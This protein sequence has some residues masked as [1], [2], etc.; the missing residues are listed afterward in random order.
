MINLKKIVPSLLILAA[1]STAVA[2]TN[3]A[4][5]RILGGEV[6]GTD[7]APVVV[8]HNGKSYAVNKKRYRA[9]AKGNHE[10]FLQAGMHSFTL[11][12]WDRRQYLKLN[13]IL[14]RN[15]SPLSN[16]PD[17]SPFNHESV[18]LSLDAN[19]SYEIALSEDSN[20]VVKFK[21]VDSA[22]AHCEASEEEILPSYTKLDFGMLEPEIQAKLIALGKSA[23][24]ALSSAN[25]KSS[26]TAVHMAGFFGLSVEPKEGTLVVTH[27]IRGS[28][29]DKLGLV[30]GD[31]ITSFGNES[32]YK[33]YISS[34]KIGQSV[35]FAI[36]REGVEKMIAGVYIPAVAPEFMYAL[37]SH[38]TKEGQAINKL[39][40]KE[41][42]QGAQDVR[43]LDVAN[44]M[45]SKGIADD[46]YVTVPLDNNNTANLS[47]A[48]ASLS[49]I[50]NSLSEQPDS[51]FHLTNKGI[52]DELQIQEKKM[53]LDEINAIRR[54][55]GSS[56]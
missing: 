25:Q 55:A 29:A 26:M 32:D 37:G 56:N 16:V 17:F 3:C 44:V 36:M 54:S 53:K 39:V 21:V 30:V 5:V 4:T 2:A 34:I 15:N 28:S 8:G 13:R 24:D 46:F 11:E 14:S 18:G 7:I 1:S 41:G 51:A 9:V 6:A 47:I 22:K 20:G 52:W 49:Q 33:Q 27:V 42:T 19:M 45:L 38:E 12:I 50:N 43:L 35:E 10:Y 23:N 48:L 40:P 31:V